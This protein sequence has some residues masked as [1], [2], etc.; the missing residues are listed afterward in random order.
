MIAAP[1]LGPVRAAYIYAVS[2]S[3]T[4]ILS[5][6]LL[7]PVRRLLATMASQIDDPGAV[8]ADRLK[9]IGYI[10]GRP[11]LGHSLPI[12]ELTPR[13]LAQLKLLQTDL[14]Q[15]S[16]GLRMGVTRNTVKTNNRSIYRK[17]GVHSRAEA[18]EVARQLG[19]L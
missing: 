11:Q 18:V 19:L 12:E 9:A 17:L 2:A 15:S 7:N 1:H 4:T 6:A 13:E 16:I 14:S 5:P 3:A 8:L 10:P